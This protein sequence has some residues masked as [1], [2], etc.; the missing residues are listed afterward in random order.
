MNVSKV[1][2]LLLGHIFRYKNIYKVELSL[3]DQNLHLLL[4][5]SFLHYRDTVLYQAVFLQ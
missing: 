5:I 3:I 1:K 2:D 4:F